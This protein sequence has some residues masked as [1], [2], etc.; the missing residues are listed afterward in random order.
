MMVEAN[1][2][3]LTLASIYESGLRGEA[4]LA[5]A[6]DAT[7]QGRTRV[8]FTMKEIENL[9]DKQTKAKHLV[10]AAIQVDIAEK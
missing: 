5:V 10:R 3:Q 6:V 7:L 9:Y 2:A 4:R 8:L 1:A